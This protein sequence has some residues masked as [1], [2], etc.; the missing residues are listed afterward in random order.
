MELL[1]QLITC[2]K[3]ERRGRAWQWRHSE[4]ASNYKLMPRLSLLLKMVLVLIV[5]ARS[6]ADL[7]DQ[8]ILTDDPPALGSAPAPAPAAATQKVCSGTT[9]LLGITSFSSPN[10]AQ[11]KCTLKTNNQCGDIFYTL[12]IN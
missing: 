4:L 2:V 8:M 6:D 9:T 7:G 11:P 3:Y 5:G 10:F 1:G 12:A